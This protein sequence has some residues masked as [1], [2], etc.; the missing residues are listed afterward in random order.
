MHNKVLITVEYDPEKADPQFITII[1]SVIAMAV[2]VSTVDADSIKSGEVK[3]LWKFN[4]DT[5]FSELNHCQYQ[6]LD[7]YTFGV[8]Y[9]PDIRKAFLAQDSNLLA[10][11][12][13]RITRWPHSSAENW[14]VQYLAHP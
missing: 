13:E 10:N 5:L 2:G 12:V 4:V 8:T 3:H 14:V 7:R 6:Y 9:S 11:L 1:T